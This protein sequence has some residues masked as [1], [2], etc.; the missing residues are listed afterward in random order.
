MR[1]Q[2]DEKVPTQQARFIRFPQKAHVESAHFSPDGQYLVT[3]S[4]DGII[5]VWNFTT[6]KINFPLYGYIYIFFFISSSVLWPLVSV[7]FFYIIFKHGTTRSTGIS[8]RVVHMAIKPIGMS[9][10]TGLVR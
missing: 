6:G 9:R 5:E 4:F 7:L 1:E 8:L 3:G 2:E 10:K